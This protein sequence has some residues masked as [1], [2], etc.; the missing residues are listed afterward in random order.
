MER[1]A[2][3]LVSRM[4]DEALVSTGSGSVTIDTLTATSASGTFFFTGVADPTTG[5]TGTRT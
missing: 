3:A 1:L 2:G 4:V 5:A